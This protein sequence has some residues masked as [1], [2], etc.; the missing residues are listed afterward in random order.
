M[1]MVTVRDLTESPD[2]SEVIIGDANLRQ[3]KKVAEWSGG[4]KVILRQVNVASHKSLIDAMSDVD[5]VANA[6]PYHLN[7]H[8]TRAAIDARKPLTDLGGVYH[9]TL[10]QLK[11]DKEANEKGVTVILGCGVAPGIADIL[12][13]FGA[14]KLDRVDEVHIRYGEVNL[15]P[16]KYKW[17]FRTVLEEFTKGPVIYAHGEFKQLPPFSGKHV[18][19]FPAPIDER[20]CCYA[21]YSGI[22]TLPKTIGKSVKIVDCAMSYVEGDE[23][24]IQVL[25]EMGLTR[26]EPLAVDGVSISPQEFLLKCAPPPDVHVRD[27]AGVVVEVS[28]EKKGEEAKY[29]Y[30]LVHEYHEKYG[31][32][33][34]AYLTGMPMSIVAQMLANGEISDK[35]V[36]PPEKSV[37]PTPFFA[38]LAKRGVRI[39][40]TV[41]ASREI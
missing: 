33:A 16:A 36:L 21:L 4:K 37:K 17:S 41:Q 13:K 15:E 28:G 14:D 20:P 9:M 6:V 1:G 34:L 31:V 26:K 29:T 22:A 40:E 35:G 11:L 8:V 19:K 27:A 32:S 18:F 24:R 7:L 25:N 30:S 23:R 10:E 5:A 12:A 39:S 3:A 2:V 38:R